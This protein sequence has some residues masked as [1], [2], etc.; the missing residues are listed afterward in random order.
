MDTINIL[1]H[2]TIETYN[3]NHTQQQYMLFSKLSKN[4]Q[5]EKFSI[6]DKKFLSDC[7]RFNM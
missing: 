3:M 5:I 7:T 4:S 1:K 2:R 6:L